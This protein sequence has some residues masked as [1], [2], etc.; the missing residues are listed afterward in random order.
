MIAPAG[1]VPSNPRQYQLHNHVLIISEE[2]LQLFFRDITFRIQKKAQVYRFPY[3]F[4][5][6][7]VFCCPWLFLSKSPPKKHTFS[8]GL[9]PLKWRPPPTKKVRDFF[10][11]L[12]PNYSWTFA[13]IVSPLHY[14]SCS[15]EPWFW[16]EGLSRWEVTYPLKIDS[17]GWKMIFPFKMVHLQRTFVH[18]WLVD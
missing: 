10:L 2:L 15:T 14:G 4:P 6:I 12:L 1:S 8:V 17:C 5:S 7:V 11:A 18:F 9:W 3:S 16:K 13:F